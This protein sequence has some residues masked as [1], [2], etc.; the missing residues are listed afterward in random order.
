MND[1]NDKDTFVKQSIEEMRKVHARLDQYS[2]AITA[3]VERATDPKGFGVKDVLQAVSDAAHLCE[4]SIEF[5]G[6]DD[7]APWTLLEQIGKTQRA[8]IEGTNALVFL[9]RMNTLRNS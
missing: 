8:I 1:K 5:F 3:A 4:S 7:P 2:T 6:D 9:L